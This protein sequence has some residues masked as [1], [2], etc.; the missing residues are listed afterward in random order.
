MRPRW[1]KRSAT[2]S[3]S[4]KHVLVVYLYHNELTAGRNILDLLVFHAKTITLA[5]MRQLL[6]NGTRQTGKDGQTDGQRL[7]HIVRAVS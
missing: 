7:M 2:I 3:V 6:L 4:S 1:S 5:V